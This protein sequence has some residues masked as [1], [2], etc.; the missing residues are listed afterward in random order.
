MRP[1][2]EQ[3]MIV[4]LSRTGAAMK[5]NAYAGTGKT[6]TLHLIANDSQRRG[7]YLAFNKAIANEARAKFPTHVT[8]TTIHSVAYRAVS[9]RTEFDNAKM[10]GY[11][12][13]HL[14]A[15]ALRLPEFLHCS[16]AVAISRQSCGALIRDA[17][18]AFLC[19]G[20]V[21][22]LPTHL[23]RYGRL[24]FLTNEE[25]MGFATLASKGVEHLW[26]KMQD[27]TDPFP[28]GHDGYVKLWA[29]SDPQ[30]H[31]DYV[32]LDEAQDSN[33]VVLGVLSKQQCPVTY[34][35]DPYQQIYEWRGAVN[36]MEGVQTKHSALLSQSFRFG[37]RIAS[38]ATQVL[39]Y[40]KA[41]QPLRGYS[42]V[43][44]H[45]GAV[46]PVAVL[47]RTN[48]GLMNNL[49]VFQS[50]N[51][52]T[53]IIGGAQ[54]LKRLLEHVTRLRQ[55]LPSEIPEFFGFRN[56]NE[57]AHFS[58][59]TE[60]AHLRTF[61]K[62]VEQCGET[63]LLAAIARCEPT[64]EMAQVCISTAHKAK[65]K[66]WDYV[67]LD[68]DFDVSFAELSGS[69]TEGSHVPRSEARLLYVAMTRGRLGIDIPGGCRKF[70]KIERTTAE[71]LGVPVNDR[72]VDRGSW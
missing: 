24:G 65:G 50:Q 52:R 14:I 23:P 57:V 13:A 15:E 59:E 66:E 6:S 20:D 68:D 16:N 46:H 45:V 62:L 21:R 61:V 48:A 34:I 64:E 3:D 60:G 26:R 29:L 30:F 56:W 22:P 28:L 10:T 27:K 69:Q 72:A 47:A 55:G 37:D 2:A 32:M 25:F 70:F 8:C 53:H 17:L 40:L 35:G 5:I 11:A 54:E 7:H 1:T 51:V 33:P 44:S 9:N 18:H 19:S 12:N 41:P 49:M 63:R 38:A 58:Q 67:R 71:T 31:A 4:S 42:A 36:A 43:N 39:M